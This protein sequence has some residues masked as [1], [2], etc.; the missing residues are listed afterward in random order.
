MI[1]INRVVY[2]T[3]IVLALVA[4]ACAPQGQSQQPTSSASAQAGGSLTVAL[5]QEPEG[6]NPYINIQAVAHVMGDVIYEGLL[7]TDPQGSYVPALASEVPSVQNGGVSAD[8]KTVTYKLRPGL[9][10]SDGTALTSA[11]VK[12]TFDA[13]MNKDN[14]VSTRAGYEEIASVTA[15]DPT[16]VMVTFKSFY[17]PFLTLFHWVL[18]AKPAA[19]GSTRFDTP[20][21]LRQPL[22]SGPFTVQEWRSGELIAMKKNP[23]YRETGKP[24][25]DQLVVRITP[26]REVS[27]AQL[28][29]G[30]AGA[31]WNLIESSIPDLQS[32]SSIK[33]QLS[34]SPNL[35]YL[36][37]N[38]SDPADA[39]KPH[40]IL[41]DANVRKALGLAVN[42]QEIVD[43]LLYGKAKV[44]NSPIPI[45]WATDTTLAPI[46]FDVAR[47]TQL[48]DQAGWRPGSDGIRTKDGKRLSLKVTTTTGDKLRDQAEQVLQAQ[49]KVVG[50]ELA[51]DNVPS[52]VLFG[53]LDKQGPLKTGKFDIVMDTWGPDIDPDEFMTLLFESASIPTAANNGAGWNFYRL[54]VPALDKAIQDARQ[55]PDLEKRK[56][57]YAQAQRLIIDSGAYIPLYKRLF[58]N[59]Y[60]TKVQG[61]KDNPWTQFLWDVKDWT[62]K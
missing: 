5:W 36:G 40:P 12:F 26:S 38:T 27:I 43:K 10:W 60:Q 50:A 18:P 14:P 56:A 48:L 32:V 62:A 41:G 37:L 1:R 35:E 15:M 3:S 13:I 57:A 58:I 8:G 34:D 17:A 11:D 22:G 42:K 61:W 45:G 54:R 16:T 53:G 51:I 49:F 47:A 55:T 39:T 28:K 2:V 7:A 30:D 20:A 9:K 23:N 44:A 19:S 29:S 21:Y 46:P 24:N 59:G 52:Q 4:G 33:L 6:L 31:V 25:L